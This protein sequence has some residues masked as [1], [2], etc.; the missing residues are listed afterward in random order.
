MVG[1]PRE[2]MLGKTDF[3]FLPPAQAKFFRAMDEAM[4]R[5]GQ[6][7]HIPEEPLTDARGVQH[8]LATTKAPLKRG[9]GNITHVVGIITD[10]TWLKLAQ[11]ALQIANEQLEQR[12]AQS[13]RELE[14]AREELL[15]KER[16]AVLG[17]L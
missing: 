9:D 12:V 6:V 7:V 2:A 17:R 10:I 13:S 14:A 5:T 15:R 1:P 16:P 11:D 4:F 3:D 8:V